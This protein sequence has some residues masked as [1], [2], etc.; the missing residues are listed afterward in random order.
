MLAKS[1]SYR[2]ALRHGWT[3]LVAAVVFALAWDNGTYGLIS[4]SS[5]AIALF[6][7]LILAL[8]LGLWPLAQLSR[9]V[10]LIGGLFAG[11][12]LW[13]LFSLAWAANAENAFI[14]F[15]RVMLYL[16]VFAVVVL[17]ATRGNLDRWRD[18]LTIAIV[19]VATVAVGSRVFP[20]LVDEQGLSQLG[21]TR[22]SFPLG[23]WNGLA[24]FLGLA[25]PLLLRSAT[26]ARTPRLRGLALAALPL[27]GTAMYFAASRGGLVSVAAG[28][29]VLVGLGRPRWRILLA[30]ACATAGSVLAVLPLVHWS[31][32][33]NSPVGS[34]AVAS[35]GRLAAVL[36]LCACVLT[37]ILW[38]FVS[39]SR[40]VSWQPPERV[41]SL[42]LGTLILAL[43][44][45]A[46]L[47]HP[48]RRFESFKQSPTDIVV[49]P[50]DFVQQHLL[51]GNGSGRWQFWA[52]AVDEWV[53][54][55]FTGAGA[56][57]YASWWAQHGS[58]S[59]F[60]TDAHS[61]YFQTLGELGLIGLLLIVGIV[62]G[63]LSIGVRRTLRAR[64]QERNTIAALVAALT[65]Y[66]VGAGIDWMWQLTTVSVVGI[67]LLA[68]VVGPG[69]STTPIG[70]AGSGAGRAREREPGRFGLG[71]AAL[72]ACWL[73]ICAQGIPL[74]AQ[75]KI[76]D[77]QAAARRGETAPAIEAAVAARDIQPWASSPYLQL[78]LVSEQIGQ[79]RE[80]HAW[81]EKA[82]ARDGRNWRLRLVAARLEMKLGRVAD[83]GRSLER[84]AALDP[85]SPLFRDVLVGRRRAPVAP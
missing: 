38:S 61:L 37:G 50:G 81:I 14:E 24:I 70:V 64:P 20:G 71:L 83:A 74:L 59:Y 65:A 47:A 41:R 16:G 48:L 13:T 44:V 21:A 45:A 5:L 39:S 77:S 85:R 31:K 53:H 72:V 67:A 82:I 73:A 6:W 15:D 42:A 40:A 18:G 10:V 30:L 26:E 52:A 56:G 57:S 58:F 22:L 4:R 8:I 12:A 29:V 17:A 27:I 55:P 36:I 66:A 33:A 63:G 23:Y 80:A 35:E 75:L 1:R 49:A 34:Q 3:S 78:A 79:P 11:L 2:F 28:T 68:L 69:T 76:A 51:S 32:L 54:H 7:T 62:G 19:A 84:A 25:V 60:V 9:A 43:L 46:V